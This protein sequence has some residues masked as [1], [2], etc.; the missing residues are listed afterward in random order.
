MS[1]TLYIFR[2][3]DIEYFKKQKHKSEKY[4]PIALTASFFSISIDNYAQ[5]T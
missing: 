1:N 4:L 2:N 3:N 5:L